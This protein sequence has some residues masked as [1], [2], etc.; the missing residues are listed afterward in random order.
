[1]LL[2]FLDLLDTQEQKNRFQQLYY[3]Y[4]NLTMWI[5]LQKLHNHQLAEEAAQDAWFYIA[6]NFKIFERFNSAQAKGYIATVAQGFAISKY[7]N[8]TKIFFE[9][10]FDFED[11]GGEDKIEF[12]LE[13]TTDLKT[14]VDLLSDDMRNLLYLRYVYGYNSTEI[15]EIYGVSAEEV[16][17]QLQ[18]AKSKVRIYLKEK[19]R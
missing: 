19:R 5:A 13:L 4:N 2:V 6:K 1:M 17:K 16:R 11:F 18:Y 7:R 12:E 3:E 15:S 10:E 8:E 14:A 9:A